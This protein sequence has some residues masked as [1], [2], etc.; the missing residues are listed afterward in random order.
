MKPFQLIVVA[1][2]VA[3]LAVACSNQTSTN[4]SASPTAG[5]SPV[6]AV[7]PTTDEFAATRVVF[8]EQCSKCHGDNGEGGP[9]TVEGKKLRVPTFKSGHALKHTDED[10]H[11]QI[12]N[13]GDGMPPFK[14][15]LTPDQV[16]E[17]V[18]FVRKQFQ[19]K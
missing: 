9:V 17:L 2:F 14:A 6:A 19:G 16:N 1:V 10:F 3:L 5:S 18:R 7:A 11:D 15:K 4:M 13:G 8:K 12:M